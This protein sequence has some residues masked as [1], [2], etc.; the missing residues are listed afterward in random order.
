MKAAA[1]LGLVVPA[2]AHAQRLVAEPG[3]LTLGDGAAATL[4]LEPP[5]ASPEWVTT[6]GRVEGHRFLPGE[7]R[8][9]GFAV[10]VEAKSRTAVVI[11]L[12][13]SGALPTNTAPGA[14]VTVEVEG[15]SFGPVTADKKGD[16]DVPVIVPPHVREVT[17]T[18]VD[19][20]GRRTVR[21][22]TL[23]TLGY[24][25]AL[26]LA[27]SRLVEG[28]EA[29][30]TVLA[31][32]SHGRWRSSAPRVA[33]DGTLKVGALRSLGAGRW[34]LPIT[35]A[36]PSPTAALRVV[37]DGEETVQTID[38]AARPVPLRVVPE[39]PEREEVSAVGLYAGGAS[40]F[41]SLASGVV[42]AEYSR[43]LR[44]R[45]VRISLLAA[46][47][48]VYGVIDEFRGASITGNLL[49]LHFDLGTRLRYLISPRMAFEAGA[50]AG[51]AWGRAST[52][53]S[54]S[55][56]ARL[57]RTSVAPLFYGGVGL[58]FALPPGEVVLE[59]RWTEL[60][61]DESTRVEG[62][63]LGATVLLGYRFQ[64]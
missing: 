47:A 60:R 6:L 18:S 19:Q 36:A 30:V 43:P 9:P 58:D 2:L 51:V 17:V 32:D 50:G 28:E 31:I 29:T 34:S 10:I 21:Q 8:A 48:A 35:A 16:A 27:P 44:R 1:L 33:S 57:V 37:V 12:W 4:R 39:R 56:T 20:Y 46:A 41:G 55:T 52:R 38:V 54:T 7:R 15:K 64:P 23:P 40:A 63:A 61:F 59:A 42:S 11:P 62:N 24:P 26:V 14:A 53:I 13:G 45:G 3:S 22:A 25:R 5:V 49:Q